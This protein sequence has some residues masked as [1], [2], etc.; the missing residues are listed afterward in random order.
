MRREFHV[1][2]CEGPRVQFPRATRLVIVCNTRADL[3]EATRRVKLIF[4]RLGLQ[5]HPDTTRNVE[6]T[7][8]KDG[9]DFLGCHLHKRM[10]GKI[11]ENEH[12]RVYFL[13]RWPSAS[14][15]KRVKQRVNEPTSRAA[16]HRD[17]RETIAK[18]NPVLRGWG[19][20]FA[21]GNA[22]RK[23]NQV[24]SY[25]WMRLRGLIRKRK[26]RDLRRGEMTRWTRDVFRQLG[27]H[28]LRGTV[29]YPGHAQL[30]RSDRPPVSRVREIRTHGLNGGLSH[31]RRETEKG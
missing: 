2:F 5:L 13:Q 23:F 28:R 11:W 27:V 24:D 29:R 16:C 4:K 10:S 12:E 30:P 18:L 19:G 14:S 1:R 21:T 6:L 8:G 26:G 22:A 15:V 3:D 17:L 20:Y 9:F 31:I 7:D 25:V